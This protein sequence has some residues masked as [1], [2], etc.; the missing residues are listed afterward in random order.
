ML[1]SFFRFFLSLIITRC[2]YAIHEIEK[3]FYQHTFDDGAWSFNLVKTSGVEN[4]GIK[5]AF[6][7]AYTMNSNT[8]FH[9]VMPNAPYTVGE[10]GYPTDRNFTQQW[11]I[12]LKKMSSDKVRPIYEA[13]RNATALFVERL[14]GEHFPILHDVWVA[15]V[16]DQQIASSSEINEDWVRNNTEMVVSVNAR[17][18]FPLFSHMG[19]VRNASYTGEKH[20]KISIQ[21]HGFAAKACMSIYGKELKYMANAPHPD[22]LKLLEKHFLGNIKND[23]ITQEPFW[24]TYIEVRDKED[25]TIFKGPNVLGESYTFAVKIMSLAEAMLE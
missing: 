11:Q 5:R 25:K 22:Y 20:K 21:L 7:K 1:F 15:F 8:Y 17:K 14:N 19:I 23:V 2:S 16:T 6:V 24:N 9:K 10:D 13:V 3:G 12:D 18:G 4:Q